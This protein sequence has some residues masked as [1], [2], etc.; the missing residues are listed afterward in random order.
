LASFSEE[1]LREL[2]QRRLQ[3]R[4]RRDF[5]YSGLREIGFRIQAKP[6][7]AFYILAECS[8]FSGDSYGFAMDLLEEAGVATAPGLDFGIHHPE[9]YLRFSYTLPIARLAEGLERIAAFV[10]RAKP[11]ASA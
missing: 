2:E 11:K 1:N 4:E 10:H 8:Q 9:R 5:L 7:G 6:E 3:F